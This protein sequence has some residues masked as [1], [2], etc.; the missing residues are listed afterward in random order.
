MLM[1]KVATKSAAKVP[2][3]PTSRPRTNQGALRW[4]HSIMNEDPSYDL[5]V[6]PDLKRAL[7]ANHTSTRKLF[8]D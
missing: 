2:K 1:K 7:E 4:L 5:K 8:R 6:W 3:R